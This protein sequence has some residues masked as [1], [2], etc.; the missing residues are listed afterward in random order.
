M[1]EMLAQFLFVI[2]LLF[3]Y[4]HNRNWQGKAPLSRLL[5]E[6]SA[7]YYVNNLPSAV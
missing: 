1:E 7:V 5:K 3:A 6:N 2:A 4:L